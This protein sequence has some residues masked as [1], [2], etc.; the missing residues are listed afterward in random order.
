MQK[1]NKEVNICWDLYLVG[2]YLVGLYITW[3]DIN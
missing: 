1:K 2:L 3:V